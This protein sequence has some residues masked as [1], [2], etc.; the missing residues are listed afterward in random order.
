MTHSD[1]A[2]IANCLLVIVFMLGIIAG[3]TLVMAAI[4]AY[5][6]GM[7]RKAARYLVDHESRP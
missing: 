1:A 6:L 7:T 3:S 2:R 4:T 5:K